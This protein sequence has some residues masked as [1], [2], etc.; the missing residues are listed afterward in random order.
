MIL[1][2][3]KA[4]FV[5][6]NSSWHLSLMINF[7]VF[8]VS[9]YVEHLNESLAERDAV[10]E[11]EISEYKVNQGKWV[12]FKIKDE[13]STLECFG[14]VFKLKFPLEDGMRVR[15][16]GR[17]KIYPK[18]GK[19]SINVE[20]VEPAGEGALKRAFELL[21]KELEK[22]GLFAPER[23]RPIPKFPKRIGLIASRESAA[24][25]DFVK[26]LK[27]RFGGIEIYL[28]HTTVQ[29][30]EAI[31]GIAEAFEYFNDRQKELNFDLIALIRGG[32]SIDD[33][34]AFNSREVAYAIFGSLAPVVC[35][36]G[37]EQDVTIADFVA[38]LRASTPS[39]AAELIAPDRQDVMNYLDGMAGEITAAAEEMISEKQAQT[40]SFLTQMDYFMG[41]YLEKLSSLAERLVLHLKFFEERIIMQESKVDSFNRLMRSFNPKA[42]LD[43][44]YAIVRKKG[45][46][47][48]SIRDLKQK[49]LVGVELKDGSFEAEVI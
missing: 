14:I 35:G 24:Y 26:V 34:A 13:E 5:V 9:E 27:H 30:S 38:D 11:G 17:P 39:N 37:H 49:D 47:I 19:F 31:S 41:S 16:Y 3:T 45:G 46:L 6:L 29:G 1:H 33:L 20:W 44:G 15:L 43:R 40:N 42:V 8:S 25:G 10:V 2:I 12:F 48:S 21:K 23:K 7:K 36:V 32:G 4:R 22:E 28:Y 18:T